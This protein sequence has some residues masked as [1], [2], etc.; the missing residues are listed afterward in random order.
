VEKRFAC[1]RSRSAV[2][3]SRR[4]PRERTELQTMFRSCI[5]LPGDATACFC[6]LPWDCFPLSPCGLVSLYLWSRILQPATS[7]TPGW[8]LKILISYCRVPMM[9]L[10]C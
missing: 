1:V 2:R 4:L 3:S 7:P 6:L 8:E 10:A 5:R 9:R